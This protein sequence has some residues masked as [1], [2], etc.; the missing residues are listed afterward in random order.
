MAIKKLFIDPARCIGCR[1]CESACRE[2]ETHPGES[3]IMIDW[4]NRAASVATQPSMCLH[5]EDP[6]APCAQSCPED[7]I[8]I[9]PEGVVQQ[10][11]P[12]LCTGC[13]ICVY[14]CPFGVLQFN[15]ATRL[16]RKCDLCYDRVNAGGNP[17]CAEVCPTQA[18]WYGDEDEFAR[19][20]NG[21]PLNTMLFGKQQ[22]Q[23]RNYHVLPE[24]EQT[25]DLLAL[26]REAEEDAGRDRNQH[27]AVWML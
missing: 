13:R 16:A 17:R 21:N 9:S 2:C 26:I 15:E 12:A 10:I 11:D 14:V 6:R 23:T 20:R 5:C 1:T 27:A 3:M 25:L 18:I 19:M 7:A 22:V 24:A 8:S 4:N